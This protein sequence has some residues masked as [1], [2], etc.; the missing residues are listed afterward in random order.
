MCIRGPFIAVNKT[1]SRDVLLRWHM[2]GP[3]VFIRELVVV[4]GLSVP[5]KD[6]VLYCSRLQEWNN[7][8]F[9]V[10]QRLEPPPEIAGPVTTG[11]ASVDSDGKLATIGA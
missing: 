11:P 10:L 5:G 7:G 3:T 2:S 1:K 8:R 9:F 6:S 4:L